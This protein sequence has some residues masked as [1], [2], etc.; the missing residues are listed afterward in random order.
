MMK[1][2]ELQDNIRDLIEDIK[3]SSNCSRA[4]AIEILSK[5]LDSEVVR[6]QIFNQADFY[7]ENPTLAPRRAKG[8]KANEI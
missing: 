5:C 2:K 7:K 1:M 6:E 4:K 8:E 3:E